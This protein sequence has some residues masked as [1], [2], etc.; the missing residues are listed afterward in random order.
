M[1]SYIR[2]C[3]Q[4]DA[5]VKE[6]SW[7]KVLLIGYSVRLELFIDIIKNLEEQKSNA[8]IKEILDTTKIIKSQRQSKNLKKI[9]IYFTFGENTTQWITKYNNKPCRIYDIIIEGKP[10]TF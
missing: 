2:V 7:H 8:N 6:H 3:F 1:C 5:F 10:Y 9:L 4:F